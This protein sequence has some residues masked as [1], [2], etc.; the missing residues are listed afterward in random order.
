MSSMKSL[1]VLASFL[2]IRPSV[3]HR[4]ENV[5]HSAPK[6]VFRYFVHVYLFSALRNCGR[7]SWLSNALFSCELHRIQLGLTDFSPH[8]VTKKHAMNASFYML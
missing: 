8:L 6:T 4:P 1:E 7:T 3:D 5:P 2:L